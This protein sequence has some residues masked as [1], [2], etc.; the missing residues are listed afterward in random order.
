MA[1]GWNTLLMCGSYGVS[2]WRS[3]SKGWNVFS[4]Q[5][6]FVVGTGSRVRVWL[7]WWCD[8]KPLCLAFP[9]F[10][11]LSW[12]KEALVADFL[13]EASGNFVWNVQF[14]RS[15]NDWEVEEFSAFFSLL[16]GK[17]LRRGEA[18]KMKWLG[19]KVGVFSVK[20]MYTILVGGYGLSFPWQCVRRTK[21]HTTV[22]F[23]VWEA[24]HG[25]ILTIDNLWRGMCIADW[26]FLCKNDGESVEHVL[27]H[28]P[29]ARGLW[30][31][32]LSILNFLWVM[33]DIVSDVLW[34]WK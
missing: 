28:Y 5:I 30:V 10:Y 14:S 15:A 2:L 26:C 33:P 19:S 29:L 9:L 17:V 23:F 11:S 25:R 22:S 12:S 34:S 6:R 13:V 7:D 3:I 27:L 8:D 31:H 24:A 4:K 18:D 20:S 32:L 16:Y 21:V 1:G